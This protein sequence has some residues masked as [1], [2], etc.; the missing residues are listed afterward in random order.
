MNTDDFLKLRAE[1][2]A[3]GRP[4]PESGHPYWDF[5]PFEPQTERC[6]TGLVFDWAVEAAAE[7]AP[8]MRAQSA[9][10]IEAIWARTGTTFDDDGFAIGH[11]TPDGHT[12]PADDEFSHHE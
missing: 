3:A 8:E 9:A 11:F 4:G 2:K 5:E 10:N 6:L 7:M 12:L 1:W